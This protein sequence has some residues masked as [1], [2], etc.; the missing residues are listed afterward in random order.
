MNKRKRTIKCKAAPKGRVLHVAVVKS[1][2]F[3]RSQRQHGDWACFLGNTESEAVDQAM[4]ARDKWEAARSGKWE[5]A[6]PGAKYEVFVGT[7]TRKVVVPK[8]EYT[9]EVIHDLD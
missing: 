1:V 3:L 6:R 4:E 8:V 2:G 5:A 7:L 9:M